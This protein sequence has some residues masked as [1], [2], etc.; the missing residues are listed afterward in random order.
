MSNHKR[1]LRL[2]DGTV[3]E[4]I[5]GEVIPEGASLHVPISLRDGLPLRAPSPLP[6]LAEEAVVRVSGTLS[7][8]RV[9]GF[10]R[11][12]RRRIV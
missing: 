8:V 2:R 5:P 3:R 7:R 12:S 4:V 9:A 6:V 1:F 11:S 10:P